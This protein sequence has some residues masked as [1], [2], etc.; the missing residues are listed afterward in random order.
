MTAAVT[1]TFVGVHAAPDHTAVHIHDVAISPEESAEPV[2][3]WKVPEGISDLVRAH[4][5]N[6]AF[7]AVLDKK[8]YNKFLQ[9]KKSDKVFIDEDGED[10]NEEFKKTKKKEDVN[11][12]ILN[13]KSCCPL[14]SSSPCCVKKRSVVNCMEH[15]K[16]HL[17]RIVVIIIFIAAYFFL[18]VFQPDQKDQYYASFR[19]GK[20]VSLTISGAGTAFT[21]IQKRRKTKAENALKDINIR[22]DKLVLIQQLRFRK[23]AEDLLKDHVY[24]TPCFRDNDSLSRLHAINFLSNEVL[25]P[26]RAQNLLMQKALTSWER[27]LGYLQAKMLPLVRNQADVDNMLLYLVDAVALSRDQNMHYLRG[28]KSKVDMRANSMR[29]SLKDYRDQQIAMHNGKLHPKSTY[30]GSAIPAVLA[31]KEEAEKKRKSSLPGPSAAAPPAEAAP[32][33]SSEDRKRSDSSNEKK[34]GGSPSA[35]GLPNS[36]AAADEALPAVAGLVRTTSLAVDSKREERRGSAGGLPGMPTTVTSVETLPAAAA[37]AR[38]TSLATASTRRGSNPS[39]R[40]N[41]PAT[42]SAPLPAAAPDAALPAAAAALAARAA[43]AAPVAR[44]KRASPIPASLANKRSSLVHK[45]PA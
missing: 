10:F 3:A 24:S 16:A 15:P 33:P 35:A 6:K 36:P 29:W 25:A 31:F 45:G 20:I 19:G 41:A 34:K 4:M 11:N 18:D 9:F 42:P 40:T 23:I 13:N 2:P 7:V 17:A 1:G 8:V 37:L 39:V 38:K 32:E 26:R 14:V 28:T 22:F 43:G 12:T 21:A 44:Q 27:S 30:A 5:E